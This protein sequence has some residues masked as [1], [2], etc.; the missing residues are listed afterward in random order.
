MKSNLLRLTIAVLMAFAV[1]TQAQTSPATL[2]A[3]IINDGFENWTGSTPNNWNI[4]P[5]STIGTSTVSSIQQAVATGTLAASQSG[6][7]A[8]N[9]RNT[10]SSYTIGIM[11]GNPIA[12]TA[13]MGYQVS[14][15]ARGKGTITCEVTDGSAA[16]SSANYN[17]ANGQS[18]SGKTWHHF[19]QTVVAPTTTN[20]AQFVLKVKSTS[21][22]TASGG[23]SINGIDVDSFVVQPY[24]PVAQASLY[25]I[26]Y[27]TLSNGNSPFFAQRVNLTG[28]IVTA[29]TPSPTGPLQY[30]IQTS[31]SNAWAAALVFDQTN[32]PNVQRG[33]SVTFACSVDEYFNMTEL[34]NISNF[35][36]VSSGNPVPAPVVLTTQ[37]LAQEMYEAVLVN[38]SGAGVSTVQTYSANFGEATAADGSSVPATFDLKNGFYNP[39]G[40]ATS[41]SSGNPGY[42]VAIGGK[43]C[44]TG[45][46]NYAFSAY[47]VVPRDSSDIIANVTSCSVGIDTYKN[48][49]HANVFP[50]PMTNA[51]TIQLPFAAQK[52]SVSLT[53]VLGNEVM[54]NTASGSEINL[55][56]SNLANGVYMVKIVAD[57]KTQVT[58]VIKN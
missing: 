7:F 37:T 23:I 45:N 9:M 22:Y 47:T 39:N 6:S 18:V 50:N 14:Y 53:D 24:T 55:N 3:A 34:V 49:L 42:Q 2:G 44:F 46:V 33:D 48:N 21:T 1:S 41:G 10:S 56:S 29:V 58:K 54:M 52:V 40:S 31:G 11:G 26:E 36:K 19:Y 25:D 28:G 12:V 4:A 30:Y 32:A 38:V 51:L 13:G 15:Y 20:N 35:T 57:G 43:Y 8:C 17:A 27:S 5:V 16:T